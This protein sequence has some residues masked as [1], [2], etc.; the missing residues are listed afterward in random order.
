M[1]ALAILSGVGMLG[2]AL[3]KRLKQGKKAR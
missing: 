1:L 2:L 3:S